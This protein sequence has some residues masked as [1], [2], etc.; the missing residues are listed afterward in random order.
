MHGATMRFMTKVTSDLVHMTF[1]VGKV[2]LGRVILRV[3]GPSPVSI[4]APFLRTHFDLNT[5]L[6]RKASGRILGIL[7][8]HFFFRAHIREQ[9]RK[10]CILMLYYFGLQR[11]KETLY[12]F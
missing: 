5:T 2:T 11:S 9:R 4:V 3:L 8:I 7:K 12:F 10:N 1:V 6:I